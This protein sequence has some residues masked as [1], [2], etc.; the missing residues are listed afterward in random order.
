M[1]AIHPNLEKYSWDI[2]LKKN[3]ESGKITSEDAGYIAA[4]IQERKS[5][6]HISLARMNLICSALCT[7]R[8]R[9]PVGYSE[10]SAGQIYAA[11]TNLQGSVSR[12]TLSTYIAIMKMF[13]LWLIDN[14]VSKV[15]S[16]KIKAIKSVSVNT[17]TTTPDQLLTL[18]EVKAL[19]DAAKSIRDRAIMATLYESGCR[20]GELLRLK[21][22]DLAFTQYGVRLSIDDMKEDQR[23]V[24]YLLFSREYLSEHKHV[25][26]WNNPDNYVFS[27]RFGKQVNYVNLYQV[28]ARITKLSGIQKKV[29]PHL[30]RKSRI[31][32][33]I[34]QNYQE[35]IIKETM[36]GNKNSAML[37]TYACLSDTDIENEFLDKAGIKKK[38]AVSNPLKPIPCPRCGTVMPADS[39][40]CSKCAMGLTEEAELEI[41]ALAHQIVADR[42]VTRK[43]AEL[44]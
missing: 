16:K 35:S 22:K 21:W 24:A 26:K 32:H 11:I 34:Q 29:T 27:T 17:A 31:T 40:F 42:D 23:R 5:T 38:S 43:R 14:E 9:L 7:F 4:F 3:Q 25:S 8:G 20:A 36:W 12:N 28:V 37:K 30:F 1:S 2:A 10:C 19:I 6:N 33:L 15:Q 18:E 41:E 39:R 44:Q 13:F